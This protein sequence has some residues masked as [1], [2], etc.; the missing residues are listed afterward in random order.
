MDEYGAQLI[1]TLVAL[2]LRDSIIFGVTA[3]KAGQ[4][5][6]GA[7]AAVVFEV[8]DVDEG[9]VVGAGQ[10]GTLIVFASVVTVPPYARARPVQIAF[11]PIV[12]PAALMSVPINVESAP[13]VV[14]SV[15]VH[16]TSQADAPPANST[17]EL[18]E[19]VSAPSILN[20]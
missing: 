14:A 7:A 6:V 4:D 16:Q 3:E 13:S 19:V 1:N 2:T 5:W 15:G 17:V 11:S 10:V 18:A 8:V 20:M 12:M 9:V